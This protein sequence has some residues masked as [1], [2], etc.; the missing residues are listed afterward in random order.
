MNQKTANPDWNVFRIGVYYKL[1]GDFFMSNEEYLAQVRALY[2][3]QINDYCR[4][5]IAEHPVLAPMYCADPRELESAGL[6][7]DGLGETTL[8]PFPHLI[9]TYQDRALLLTTGA[10]FSRCRFCFR[11]R[12]WRT[13]N[14]VMQEVDESEF[15]KILQWLKEHPEV[16]DILLSGGD[17]MTL[18][19]HKILDLIDRLFDTGTIRTCRICSR[20]PAA[21]PE[22]I[23]ELFAAELGKR[24][25]VWFICHFNHPDELTPE[26]REA[27]RRLIR[28]GVPM[29][30]QAVLLAGVNDSVEILHKLFKNLAQLR[31]KPHYLF[32]VDPVEGVSH[33]ATGVQKGLEIME[34][35]RY[36]LSSLARPDFAID[37]PCGG[38]KVV[39]TPDD[40]DGN[41]NYWSAVKQCYMK[42]PLT[43]QKKESE[44]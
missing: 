3:E 32:H 24:E 14:P 37:L 35:F 7:T 12:L 41:G 42:H 26:A 15:T 28:N 29:L 38:G 6:E 18:P 4:K 31:V 17:V 30:N 19:D 13:D 27:C 11:K 5:L 16:D 1:A 23:T 43:H 33:F 36:T 25:G 20:A 21:A 39:L 8:S 40:Q 9:R 2:P 34:S 22:R 10:C 44:S